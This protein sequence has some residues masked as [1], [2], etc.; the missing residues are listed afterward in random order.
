MQ[1]FILE[2]IYKKAF[3]FDENT[4]KRLFEASRSMWI[5]LP[6]VEKHDSEPIQ[7]ACIGYGSGFRDLPALLALREVVREMALRR[8]VSPRQIH[9]LAIEPNWDK[10]TQ[11]AGSDLK[12]EPTPKAFYFGLPGEV[13]VEEGIRIEL[14]RVSVE[15]WLELGFNFRWDAVLSLCVLHLLDDWKSILAHFLTNLNVG[16]VFVFGATP[17]SVSA[18]DGDFRALSPV[19]KEDSWWRIWRYIYEIRA[20]L[21]IPS[22]KIVSPRDMSF[23]GECLKRSGYEF[24]GIASVAI[25]SSMSSEDLNAMIHST[26]EGSDACTL[27]AIRINDRERA[28]IFVEDASKLVEGNNTFY[29]ETGIQLLG[30]LKIYSV[31]FLPCVGKIATDRSAAGAIECKTIVKSALSTPRNQQLRK[32]IRS[33]AVATLMYD[34]REMLALSRNTFCVAT[35]K[36]ALGTYVGARQL[37]P[38][39][40]LGSSRRDAAKR[41]IFGHAL[42]LGAAQ[43]KHL[44]HVFS[45]EIGDLSLE[46]LACPNTKIPHLE[47]WYCSNGHPSHIQFKIPRQLLLEY[48]KKVNDDIPE[49]VRDIFSNSNG[50]E[51]KGWDSDSGFWRFY[52]EVEPKNIEIKANDLKNDTNNWIESVKQTTDGYRNNLKQ[53]LI[54]QFKGH[55]YFDSDTSDLISDVLSN[56]IRLALIDWR[57]KPDK[58]DLAWRSCVYILRKMVGLHGPTGVSLLFLLSESDHNTWMNES[59]LSLPPFVAAVEPYLNAID[60][61]EGVALAKSIYDAKLHPIEEVEKAIRFMSL[62]WIEHWD[63]DECQVHEENAWPHFNHDLFQNMKATTRRRIIEETRINDISSMKAL[64]CLRENQR[65]GSIKTITIQDFKSILAWL[66]MDI[67]LDPNM[68]GIQ[69]PTAPGIVFLISLKV[70][71]K[72][73]EEV[74][75]AEGI[76]LPPDRIYLS[77]FDAR[78]HLKFEWNEHGG[79]SAPASNLVAQMTKK[80]G[81]A[82][83]ALSNLLSACTTVQASSPCSYLFNEK[84][85]LSSLIVTDVNDFMLDVSW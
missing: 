32:H 7:I 28:E 26:L 67:S 71:I 8:G 20:S 60:E 2:D 84:Q 77:R 39:S 35:T 75:S 14:V 50:E 21:L 17:G 10:Q 5:G 41:L 83:E 11:Y 6:F 81:G 19:G 65:H 62:A 27:G 25:A 82:A 72:N 55:T 30:Y 63:H 61:I 59:I 85:N 74:H 70:F 44:S 22:A 69:L 38:M 80:G 43:E 73:L 9:V 56:S 48:V 68:K 3:P 34:M 64:F 36:G 12:E 58:D 42:Y 54:G 49:D 76:R 31:P 78:Y 57:E 37:V 47:V 40:C 1:K 45:S 66:N 18:F 52:F 79:T 46:I 4:K 33:E 53:I 51:Y 15:K 23:L 16:G 29:F 24:K 13:F